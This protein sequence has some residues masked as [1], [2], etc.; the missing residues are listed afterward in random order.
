[1]SFDVDNIA[2]TALNAGVIAA[3]GQANDLRDYLKARAMLLAQGSADLARDRLAGNINDDDVRFA[4]QEI[5]NSEVSAQL[6][7]QAALKAAVQDATNA[8]LAVVS[9]AINK[10]AGVAIL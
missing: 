1:M 5:K 6:V 8:M 3:K 2:K 9:A 7:V 4:F 10:A